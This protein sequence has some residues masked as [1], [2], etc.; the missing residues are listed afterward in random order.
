M[1]KRVQ[2]AN[3][4]EFEECLEFEPKNSNFKLK[5]C[6]QFNRIRKEIIILL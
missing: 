1:N 3:G 2:G 6:T 4:H 5:L